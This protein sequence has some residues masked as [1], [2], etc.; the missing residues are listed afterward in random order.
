MA[1]F[2]LAHAKG[3]L[4]TF[5]SKISRIRPRLFKRKYLMEELLYTFCKS[6]SAMLLFD[7][8]SNGSNRMSLACFVP[9]IFALKVERSLEKI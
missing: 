1:I 4:E 6:I 7:C 9:E 8:A 2:V 3:N 5:V